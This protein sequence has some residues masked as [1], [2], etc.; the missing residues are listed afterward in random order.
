MA[1][2]SS[3]G[4]SVTV[5]DES[6]YT[7][8]APGTTP[9][10]IVTSEESKQNGAGTGIAAGTLKANAGQVYLLTS[11]KDLADTF[12]TPVFK[13]DANNNPIH[14]GEQNEYGLQAAYSYLGVSN[15]AFVVRAD[16]DVAQLDATGTAPTGEAADGTYW[17][18]VSNTAFGIFE[19]DSADAATAT[20]QTF[21]VKTPTVITDKTKLVGGVVDG[22]PLPSIGG[23]GDYAIVA[24]TTLNTLYFK[25]PLTNSAAGTWIE[26]GSTAWAASWPTAQGTVANPT[27]T[28]T[29]ITINTVS[30][31]GFTT[32][33]GMATDINANATLNTAGIKA[34]AINNKLELYST[35][36]SLVVSG[37]A[38]VPVGIAAATYAAPSLALSAHTSIP[39]WKRT[40]QALTANG[41]ATGSLWVKTTNPNRGA[42]WAVKKYNASVGAWQALTAPLYSTNAAALASLDSTGGGINLALGQLYVKYNDDE[43]SGTLPSTSAPQANFKIY[44]RRGTGATTVK[45]NAISASTFTAGALEFSISYTQK[46]TAT[47]SSVYPIQFTATASTADSDTILTAINAALPSGS[48][49]TATKITSTNQIQLTHTAGGDIKL[50]NVTGTPLA[51]L[52][53]TTTTANYYASPTGVSTDFVVSLWSP[54]V[55][56]S[57]GVSVG[58]APASTDAPT[59]VP[60]DGRLWYNSDLTEIDIMVHNGTYWVGYLHFTQNGGG[61]DT[62]DPAGPLISATKPTKQSDGTALANGDLWIDTSDLENFPR[63]YKFNY[64]TKKWVLVDTSDQSTENGILF[65]DARYDTTGT[66]SAEGSIVELLSTDFV[67]ADAPS[68]A[69]YPRGMLLWN[70][71]RSGFNVKRYVSGYVDTTARNLRYN[72]SNGT[73][74]A[75]GSGQLMTSYYADRWVSEAANQENGAGT[76][77]RKAQR[78]VVVQ[79][80]QALVNANQQIRDE[81][82]RVF[83]LIACP[84]YSELVGEM[85]SLNYDRGLTAFVVADT[86]SRLTPDATSL[87]NWGTNQKG[88]VEDNDDGLVSSDEYLGFF[89]PWG[90]TSDN[91]GNNVVVPPSHMML[92]TIALSDN[93][94][95]PWFAPAGTRRGGITNAT[96]VGYITSEGEFQSVALNTGQRDTLASI[97]V[98]PLT[99]ITGTGLVNYGQYTRAKNASSLDRINVARLVIYLRRQFAQLAKPYVFE[100]NDKITR[101]EIKQAAESLLLELVGQRALYDYLVVCDTSN[102]TPSRI[103]RNEL[104]L[105]VA[106]EPVKAVEFIYI[107]LRLKNTGEIKGLA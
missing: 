14:A 62:T 79:K 46:G 101:D 94:S 99:F 20:G 29:T 73:A 15:R 76:F 96:A 44:T 40:D 104:Y 67:D 98:N 33:T 82:A 59:T 13:T 66:S 38:C 90:F 93:V 69:L 87:L 68:P 35:G 39:L 58:I 95:Y 57:A 27:V 56:N 2:L 53:S 106:I 1:Q 102:N 32:V 9:L 85:V 31:T 19:W 43:G 10:I 17:F 42:D 22:I 25:K 74:A 77:G 91:I 24:T 26:V 50:S 23:I 51:A 63:L 16:I 70:L 8:A 47:M 61:G 80:L 5:I 75:I 86:P 107:P 48:L 18:D 83:N 84:G 89:Y 64:A 71:R 36:T 60:A 12:G 4:V 34:A 6:F 72:G 37:T 88:A 92:R 30:V 54:T 11:Q 41:Q 21:I 7:P 81:E 100:P 28:G 45:T 65:A 103:D 49:V 105:D 52:F 55:L 97:K 78:K 3:P